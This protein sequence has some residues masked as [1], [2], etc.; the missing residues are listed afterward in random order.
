VQAGRQVGTVEG[1]EG[2]E[3]DVGRL[4]PVVESAEPKFDTDTRIP[5]GLTRPPDHEKHRRG[6][7]ATMKSS[8]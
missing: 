4:D 1:L 7:E 3:G 2:D 6:N 5:R 8:R